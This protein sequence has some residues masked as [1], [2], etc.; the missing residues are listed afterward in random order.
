MKIKHI[1]IQRDRH[2]FRDGAGRDIHGGGGVF[3]YR[4]WR[5]GRLVL[6]I[7]IRLIPG[8]PFLAIWPYRVGPRRWSR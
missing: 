5:K 2:T 3:W 8:L 1:E 6:R 7:Y 4:T